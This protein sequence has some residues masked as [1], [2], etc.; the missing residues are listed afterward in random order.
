LWVR[1]HESMG[2]IG[3]RKRR[4]NSDRYW[5]CVSGGKEGLKLKYKP[6]PAPTAQTLGDSG[7]QA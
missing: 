6:G 1:C 3:G 4:F 5:Q 2:K 7:Q